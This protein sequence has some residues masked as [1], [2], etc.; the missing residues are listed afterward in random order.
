MPGL[1]DDANAITYAWFDP[2]R[3]HPAGD[4][5]RPKQTSRFAQSEL[6]PRGP[7]T[8][9]VCTVLRDRHVCGARALST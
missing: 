9:L 1:A 7:G 8:A 3:L 2:Q 6:P 4:M 5:A